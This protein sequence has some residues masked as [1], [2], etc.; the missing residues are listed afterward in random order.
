MP[1]FLLCR[2]FWLLNFGVAE[3]RK[4]DSQPRIDSYVLNISR[5]YI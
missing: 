1:I 2:E 5:A 3:V 4:L